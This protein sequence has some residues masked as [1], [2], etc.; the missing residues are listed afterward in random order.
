VKTESANTFDEFAADYDAALDQGLKATGESRAFFARERIRCLSESLFHREPQTR[1]L[2]DFG[3]GTG[4]SA[5]ILLRTLSA[6]SVVGVEPSHETL[7][8]ARETHQH[9]RIRFVE[10]IDAALR[11]TIDLV[12]CNGVFHHID[13]VHRHSVLLEIYDAMVPGAYFGFWENNP[14]NPGTRWV[15]SRI[16]FDRDAIPI[17]PREARRILTVAGFEVLRTDYRFIF[18]RTLRFLR[19]TEPLL[20]RFPIGGQY[21]VL[22]R[23]PV[24]P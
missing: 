1:R 21:Q 23:K 20:C 6:E 19:W 14:W 16:P 22:C 7:R 8:I 18:P 3:C 2:M 11:E 9:E 17:S 24:E 10:S 13:P 12:Y 15:M 4:D 5:A